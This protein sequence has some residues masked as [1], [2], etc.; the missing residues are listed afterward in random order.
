VAKTD[1]AHRG[2]SEQFAAHGRDGRM[3]RAYQAIVWG[4]MRHPAGTI[5]AALA[6]S[7]INR[8]KIAV[9]SGAGSRHAVTHWKRL[10]VFEDRK[11]APVASLLR[12]ELETGRTH[13]IRVHLA[14]VGHPLLG[15]PTYGAGFASAARRL[16]DEGQAALAHLGRQALHAAHLGFEHP[17]SGRRMAFDSPLPPDLAALVDVLRSA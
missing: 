12:V 3:T 17:T 5:D 2:L 15:D 9:Q 11:G 10:A 13:Q 7:R 6:R 16:S 14:H 8:T 4:A 1:A